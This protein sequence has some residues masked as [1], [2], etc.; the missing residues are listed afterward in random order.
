VGATTLEGG[1]KANAKLLTSPGA[2]ASPVGCARYSLSCEGLSSRETP[3]RQ[4]TSTSGY[5]VTPSTAL[6][7][8]HVELQLTR[9]DPDASHRVSRRTDGSIQMFS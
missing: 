7:C 5:G 4:N 8:P 6:P 9:F 3:S 2:V 1:E